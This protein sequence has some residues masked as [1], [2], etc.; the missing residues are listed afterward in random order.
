MLLTRVLWFPGTTWNAYNEFG[1]YC[2]LKNDRRVGDKE[3][4]LRRKYEGKSH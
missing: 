1:E 2:I 3:D 4:A